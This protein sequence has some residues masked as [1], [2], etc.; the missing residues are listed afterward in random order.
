[1]GTNI[2]P[3]GSNNRR[4]SSNLSIK[5]KLNN[6]IK[7]DQHHLEQPSTREGASGNPGNARWVACQQN[8]GN[9]QAKKGLWIACPREQTIPTLRR[10]KE[11]CSCALGGKHTRMLKRVP[12]TQYRLGSSGSPRLQATLPNC[13]PSGLGNE[14]QKV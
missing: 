7:V 3:S 12:T 8:R 14:L 11:L 4:R 1:M 2:S 10:E 9:L 5:P 6:A 13:H